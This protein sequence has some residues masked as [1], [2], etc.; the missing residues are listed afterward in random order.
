MSILI[1]PYHPASVSA[2]LLKD[3]LLADERLA[4]VH[5]TARINDTWRAAIRTSRVF[6]NWG[7]SRTPNYELQPHTGRT[8]F[9]N[10]SVVVHRAG[11]KLLSFNRLGEYGI[12][13]PTYSTDY[14]S[15]LRWLGEGKEVLVRTNLRGHSGAGI[16]ILSPIGP[17]PNGW[18]TAPLYVQY[19]KK[20]FEYRVHVFNGQ[21]IDIQQKRKITGALMGDFESKI[22]SHR[23]GWVFCREE[24]VCPDIPSLKNL[25][26]AAVAALELQ[27]GAVDII[28][29][30]R[31]NKF[32]VLEVNT[33]PG[34][35][36]TTLQKY[37]E[38]I[39]Q[40]ALTM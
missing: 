25:A 12:S 27:F 40:A 4:G 11:N 7:S 35:E 36:G 22:R 28:Y 6:I 5:S 17:L 23:N 1:Y 10:N 18:E 30:E 29:N 14:Q 19:K 32:Y 31:E 34:L 15:A 24:L 20:R 3:A 39:V 16:E 26:I 9:L 8:L 37:K 2:R 38:A 21:V 13:I 33:A